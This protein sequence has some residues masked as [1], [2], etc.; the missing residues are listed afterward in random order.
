ML[1]LHGI[2]RVI[3]YSLQI[4]LKFFHLTL[5]VIFFFFNK[6]QKKVGH[7]WVRRVGPN[8]TRFFCGSE[9]PNRKSTHFVGRVGLIESKVGWVRVSLMGQ[10]FCPPK[11]SVQEIC[12][13]KEWKSVRNFQRKDSRSDHTNPMDL[14]IKVGT[15]LCLLIL[16]YSN[17]FLFL[18]IQ[19]RLR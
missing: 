7:Y 1:R 15:H 9:K 17:L 12:P 8:S 14:T 2:W 3:S 5:F 4:C 6:S 13:I 19:F 18:Y 11:L 10:T 16:C